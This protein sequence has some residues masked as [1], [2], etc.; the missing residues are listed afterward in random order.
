MDSANN[1]M[2]YNL[3]GVKYMVIIKMNSTTVECNITASEIREI[4]L[5][6]EAIINGEDKSMEFMSQVNKEM[7]QQIGFDPENEVMMMAKNML[8]DGSVHIFAIKLN[9]DDIKRASDRIRLSAEGILARVTQTKVEEIMRK[10]G[11]EKGIALNEMINGVTEMIT[12]MYAAPERAI[13]VDEFEASSR[14]ITDYEKYMVEFDNINQVV[15]F[16][17][18]VSRL[19]I[20]DSALYKLGDTYYMMLGLRSSEDDDIYDLR[21]A[22]I[23]YSN[24]LS[25]GS[26]EMVHVSEMATCIVKEDAIR[27]M[28]EMY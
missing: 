1:M 3:K 19:P 11:K 4:G 23:E 26:P 20:E 16:S 8:G 22:G 7:G 14:Q 28:A 15:R 10:K 12:S 17:N 2:Y 25:S 13:D 9:N 5:T 21:R 18:V 27:H 24:L 6:P